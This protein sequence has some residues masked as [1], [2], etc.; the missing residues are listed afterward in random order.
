MV[1]K[2]C[3]YDDGTALQIHYPNRGNREPT[4]RRPRLTLI[5]WVDPSALPSDSNY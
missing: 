3:R 5:A 4:D 1:G 2:V